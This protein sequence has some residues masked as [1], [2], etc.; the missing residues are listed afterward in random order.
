MIT[1][2]HLV[3]PCFPRFPVP[4]IYYFV[5]P[6]INHSLTHKIRSCARDPSTVKEKAEALGLETADLVLDHAIYSKALEILLKE[7]N[8][9]LK[10][11]MNLR[12]GEFHVCCSFLA[13]I[14]K[15]FGDAMLKYLII[16]SGLHLG[17]GT[18]EQIMKGK[19][20]N[21]AMRFHHVVAEA[22]TQKEIDAFT[23][24]LTENEDF[25]KLHNFN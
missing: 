21:N 8:E 17:D 23:D 19:Q 3:S 20:F 14:G 9:V 25:N 16:E 22:L 15:H 18:V 5:L 12:M 4:K 24:W 1:C 11:F 7:R 13:V 6:S 2:Y 10:T